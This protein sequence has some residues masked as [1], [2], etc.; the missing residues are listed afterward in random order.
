[1]NKERDWL[2]IFSSVFKDLSKIFWVCM[3]IYAYV[4]SLHY[5]A[6][7][8]G[9]IVYAQEMFMF[10]GLMLGSSLIYFILSVV[11]IRRDKKLMKDFH[12]LIKRNHALRTWIKKND[13]DEVK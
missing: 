12:G 3:F 10:L 11:K 7:S 6:V 8:A 1:M 4:A 5:M 2:E 9:N 13:S